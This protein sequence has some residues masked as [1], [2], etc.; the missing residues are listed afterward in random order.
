M[1]FTKYYEHL[2]FPSDHFPDSQPEVI[3]NIIYFKPFKMDPWM[4]GWMDE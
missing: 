3:V 2:W 4:D 1:S